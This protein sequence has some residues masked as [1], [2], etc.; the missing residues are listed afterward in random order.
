VS[1]IT[2]VPAT[3]LHLIQRFYVGGA[4]RQFIER[5]RAHP[6]GFEPVVGCLEVSGGNLEEFR[7]LGI[8]EPS[9]FPLLGSLLRPNTFRQ[10]ARIAELIR[11]RGCVLVHGT[12]FVTNFL[13]VCAARLAGVPS[14]VS[15]VDMGH[16][17]PGFGPWH[18]RLEK[19]VSQQADAVCA[20]A[21]A[22]RRLCIEEEG[23]RPENVSVV[24][25]GIDLGRFDKLAAAPL[26]APVPDGDPLV[27]VVAN[28]WPVK[29]HRLLLEAIR[30]MREEV[31]RA[32]FLLVG[33]GPERALLEARIA[34][35]GLEE[36]V[37]L[38]GTRYD[39]PA[40]L[41]R[42]HAFCLPSRGEG[43]SNALME[44]MAAGLPAIATDVGGNAELVEDGATGFIVPP[45]D[46]HAL[47]ARLSDLL[48]DRERARRM[49]AAAR[50]KASDELS[51]FA[52]SEG[53]RNLYCRIL[54]RH[55][56]LVTE[57][58]PGIAAGRA[59]Q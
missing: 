8:G 3:V 52:M 53:Y 16:L 31:P 57:V 24:K 6:E 25:N 18:R 22:V 38:L 33:D 21:E 35:R 49:G 15:R 9:V 37:F 27:V 48:T 34:A 58:G 14:L 10:I 47:A 51:L 12:D 20:N 41:A 59:A 17:R 39:V 45:F 42:A 7:G 2:G 54:D 43:L 23:C 19:L 13:G 26:Q 56:G 29:G 32:R 55:I 1:T 11:E 40:L 50:R 46:A 4:E 44:A 30:L 36:T 28:L 5:L